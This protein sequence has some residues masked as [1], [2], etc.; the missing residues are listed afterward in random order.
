MKPKTQTKSKKFSAS[1]SN[2]AEEK[3]NKWLEDFHEEDR[4]KRTAWNGKDG[5]FNVGVTGIIRGVE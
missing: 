4:S 1:T 3:A 5:E 2:E